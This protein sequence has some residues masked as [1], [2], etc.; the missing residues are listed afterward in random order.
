VY[1]SLNMDVGKPDGQLLM[2]A[3]DTCPT[4]SRRL[5]MR[6][7]ASGIHFLVDTGADICVFPRTLVPGRLRKSDY[8]LG[9]C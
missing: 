1:L 9:T 8:V 3:D 6:D 2:A 7:K 5:F 4:T